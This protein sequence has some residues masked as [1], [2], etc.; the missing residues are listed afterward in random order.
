MPP[1]GDASF[2]APIVDHCLD[3]F[4]PRRVLFGSDWPVCL[5]G[6]S[7]LTWVRYLNEIVSRRTEEDQ[8]KLWSGN[9]QQLYSI[10][11]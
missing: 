11:S 3:Q 6:A 1:D 4:G 10:G 8:R 2:L 7:L 9:A 5:S